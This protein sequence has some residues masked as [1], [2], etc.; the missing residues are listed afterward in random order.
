MAFFYKI[1]ILSGRTCQ[2]RKSNTRRRIIVLY[3]PRAYH[4]QPNPDSHSTMRVWNRLPMSVI[5]TPS[6]NMMYDVHSKIEMHRESLQ[7]G[8]IPCY[9]YRTHTSLMIKFNC[10]AHFRPFEPFGL[11][12][13]AE[14]KIERE[15]MHTHCIAESTKVIGG[16]P[17]EIKT[18]IRYLIICAYHIFTL[19]NYIIKYLIL[20]LISI[21][22]PMIYGLSSTI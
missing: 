22:N 20:V 6:H 3:G 2:H 13:K 1:I 17:M 11:E 4:G 14:T 7:I 8:T 21:G 19:W 18:K 10:L 15:W 9:F 5:F 12:R 16:F